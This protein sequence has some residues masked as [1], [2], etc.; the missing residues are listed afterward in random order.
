MSDPFADRRAAMRE[1]CFACLFLLGGWIGGT[2][3][4]KRTMWEAVPDIAVMRAGYGLTMRHGP[5]EAEAG[6]QLIMAGHEA[7]LAQWFHR[8]LFRADIELAAQ[9]FAEH[10]ATKAFPHELWQRILADQPGPEI[11]LPVDIWGF[12]GGQTFL[13][14]TPCLFFDGPGG[15]V[16]YLEP[17]M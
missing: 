1:E 7:M 9:W 17:A 6:D 14:Q 10:A 12:P 15:A 13:P 16:S 5:P 11:R 3:T 4:Y 2:D 8:P